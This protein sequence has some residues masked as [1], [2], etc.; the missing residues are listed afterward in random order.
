MNPI[1]LL[2]LAALICKRKY[3]IVISFDD[4]KLES[5]MLTDCAKGIEALRLASERILQ[6]VDDKNQMEQTLEEVKEILNKPL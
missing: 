1:K 6:R 4:D 3:Y 2:K 5:A